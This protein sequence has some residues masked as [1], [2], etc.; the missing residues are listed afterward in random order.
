MK[1]LGVK[2]ADLSTLAKGHESKCLPAR[3]AHTR[4]MVSHQWLSD[5]LRMGNSTTVSTDIKRVKQADERRLVNLKKKLAR[6]VQARG[7]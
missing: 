2:E 5:R 1:C 7:V 4:T 3:L 6:T